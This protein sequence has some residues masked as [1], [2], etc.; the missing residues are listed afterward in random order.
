MAAAIP[1]LPL[2]G[3][4]HEAGPHP[5]AV[6]LACLLGCWFASCG[7]AG[8]LLI[9]CTLPGHAERSLLAYSQSEVNIA[10]R[11]NKNVCVGV[12]ACACVCVYM[13]L[14]LN[15]YINFVISC[16]TLFPTRRL[17]FRLA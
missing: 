3:C 17:H 10:N 1:S 2:G 6:N 4:S 8:R 13:H 7:A 9:R 12:Y 16:G 11:R 15:L 5:L 14:H